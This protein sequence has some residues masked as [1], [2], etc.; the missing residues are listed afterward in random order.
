VVPLVGT[1]SHVINR[2]AIT[3]SRPRDKFGQSLLIPAG[4][5]AH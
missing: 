3:V 1:G 2:A 5:V 4:I